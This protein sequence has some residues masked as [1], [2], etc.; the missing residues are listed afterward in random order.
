MPKL[1]VFDTT[2]RDGEQSLGITL[3]ADQ[4][5]EIARQLAKLGVDVIEVGFPA[6]SPADLATIRKVGAEVKGVTICGLSRAVRSDIDACVEALQTAEHPR[7][8][9]GL[10]TSPIHMERKLRKTPDQV[11][12]MAV[13]AVRY[14]R[15]FVPDV[16]FY[17]EDAFRSDREFLRRVFTE[18]IRAGATVINIPDTVGYALPWQFTEFVEWLIENVDGMDRVTVSVHCHNDLGMATANSLAGIRAGALQV[19]GTINGIGERAGN[20]ALEEI[21]MAIVAHKD[22]FGLDVGIDTREFARTSR[23]VADITGV[24]VQPYKAIVG[25]NAYSHASG[26]HQ[27]GVLK[28]RQTYEIIRP[29][30][31]G[32]PGH[33]IVLTS[34][35]GRHALRV[36][37]EKMGYTFDRDTFERV[38]E[39]FLTLADAKGKVEEADLHAIARLEPNTTA[40]AASQN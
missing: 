11:L 22:E 31:V 37:L 25:T 21:V 18:V 6:S 27:D 13:D 5:L 8:H 30:D 39:A 26:I 38:H 28:D 9:T 33:Q 1:Q 4:K 10:A 16:E 23:L 20:A 35:S 29:E 17:A 32:M 14:A 34:R 40:S 7:I 3:N 36:T 19:E 24:P 2:L 15:R 12:E